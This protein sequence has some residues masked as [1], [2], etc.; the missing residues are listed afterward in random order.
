M[1][2]ITKTDLNTIDISCGETVDMFMDVVEKNTFKTIL[3]RAPEGAQLLVDFEKFFTQDC[4][5]MLS[6]NDLNGQVAELLVAL[7]SSLRGV[8]FF[9]QLATGTTEIV[10][11]ASISD[12][13]NLLG[14][15]QSAAG[16]VSRVVL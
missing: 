4:S 9:V 6:F 8:K 16:I 12:S 3:G 13:M 7:G 15:Q 10:D 5:A 11:L 1:L 2:D 14:S